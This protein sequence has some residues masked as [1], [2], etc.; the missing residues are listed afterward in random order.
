MKHLK[1]FFQELW[2][3]ERG[4]A[5]DIPGILAGLFGSLFGQDKLEPQVRATPKTK[6]RRTPCHTIHTNAAAAHTATLANGAAS[7]ALRSGRGCCRC[8]AAPLATRWLPCPSGWRASGSI[9]AL[10]L[11]ACVLS[12][13]YTVRLGSAYGLTRSLR[14][15]SVNYGITQERKISG[16]LFSMSDT[17]FVP[18]K[19]TLVLSNLHNAWLDEVSVAI[20]RKSG[21]AVSRSGLVRAM[22]AAMSQSSLSLSACDSEEA[23]GERILARLSGGRGQR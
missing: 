6:H 3:D 19:T 10:R 1:S 21:A 9:S 17:T 22:I 7:T 8:R 13:G 18:E 23:I 20:R 2:H 11:R 5:T 16:E 15:R 14:P 12:R 4:Q